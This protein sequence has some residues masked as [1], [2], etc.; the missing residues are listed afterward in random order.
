MRTKQTMRNKATKANHRKRIAELRLAFVPVV[1]IAARLRISTT[2]VNRELRALSKEWREAASA[3]TEE[4]KNREL[5]SLEVLEKKALAEWERSR[6]DYSKETTERVKA[7]GSE[8]EFE[9]EPKVV[10]R[11]TGGRLGD[12]KLLQVIL[13]IKE[14]R[15]KLLGLNAPMKVAPTDPTGEKPYKAMG[16]QEIAARIAELMGKAAKAASRKAAANVPT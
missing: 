1:E 3:D 6:K 9:T 12:P 15:A 10:K 14:Q 5:Q 11:E 7:S 13:N 4:W 8:G 16:D 2:T